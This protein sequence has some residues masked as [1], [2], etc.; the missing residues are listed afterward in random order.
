M[1]SQRC[2]WV[3]QAD[4]CLCTDIQ[5]FTPGQKMF[6]SSSKPASAQTWNDLNKQKWHTCPFSSIKNSW[7]PPSWFHADIWITARSPSDF[8]ANV[9]LRCFPSHTSHNDKLKPTAREHYQE[10]AF[11]QV[12]YH[13]VSLRQ[14]VYSHCCIIKVY[15]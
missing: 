9:L 15:W 6:C 5:M 8:N 1:I 11:Y 14:P 10:G 2:T 3:Q 12:F 7:F 13:R 4:I